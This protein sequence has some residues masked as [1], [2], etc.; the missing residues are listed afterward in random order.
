MFHC[1]GQLLIGWLFFCS[2]GWLPGL[3]AAEPAPDTSK[4]P[5]Q[6]SFNALGMESSGRW[7]GAPI[8]AL[9]TR[10]GYLWLGTAGGLAKFDGARFTFFLPPNAPAFLKQLI[11]CLYEDQEG[12]LW[13]GAD[14]GLFRYHKGNFEQIGLVDA[15]IS[16]VAQDQAGRMWIGTFGKGLYSWQNGQFQSYNSNPVMPGLVVRCL[17]VDSSDRIWVGFRKA[18][19][20]ICGEKGVFRHYDAGGKLH[21]EVQAVCEQ[22]RGTLWFGM[23]GDGIFRLKDNSVY[24]CTPEN[25]LAGT[26]IFDL[27]PS[28]D[29][30]VWVAEGL[31]QK[32]VDPD[33]CILNTIIGVPSE[34]IHAICEDRERNVW[35]CGFPDGLIRGCETPYRSISVTD[36]L[37]GNGVKTVKADGQGNLWMA[38]QHEGVVKMSPDGQVTTYTKNDGLPGDDPTLAYPA[39]DG[40]VWIGIGRHLCVYRDGA[41]KSYPDVPALCGAYEDHLGAMWLGTEDEGVFRYKDGAFG[42]V[43][44]APGQPI[45]HAT[46]FFETS[47]GTMYI[48]TWRSGI[49]KIKDGQ[50][51]IYDHNN[52]L[53]TDDV[54]AV[55]VD[56]E[57]HIWAGLRAEGLAVWQ[58]GRW[59]H[60]PALSQ[61]VAYQVT[62]IAEDD[63]HQLWLGTRHGV[64]W[65][66][67]DALL[68]AARGERSLPKLQI[69][70]MVDG[71]H[72]GSVWSGAQPV[73][74][75]RPDHSLLFATHFGVLVIDPDH[76]LPN[77]VPPPVHIEK[78]TLDGRTVDPADTI[79]IPAGVKEVVI[80]YTAL[81][82]SQPNL[83]SFK[84]MLEGCDRD[85][86]DVGT[87][88]VAFYGQ[89]PAR[90]YVFRVKACNSDGVWNDQGAQ[91]SLIQQ[92]HFYERWWFYGVFF[93][94]AAG[95]VL[96]FSRW[97]NH[98]LKLKLERLEQKQA[99]EREKEK[100]R[101]RIARNLH[102]GLGANLTEIGLFAETAKHPASSPQTTKD[103]AFLSERVRTM[104][105]ALDAVVWVVNPANDSLDRLS[106][107]ICEIFEAL[108]RISSIRGRQDVSGDIPPY[109]VT[110]EERSNFF[111]TAKEAINNMVKHSG[112]TEGRLRIKI[113]ADKFCLTLEDNGVG[114]DPSLPENARRNG[115]ANMRA[116]IA[117]LKG[118]FILNSTPGKGTSI[119]ISVSLARLNKDSAFGTR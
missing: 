45:P 32:I 70:D 49:F 113:E 33:R 88:R 37:P 22:P 60:T 80:E 5:K 118:T 14:R 69:V 48:G 87:R 12:N 91:I 66:P 11:H 99:M 103:M 110:P 41:F 4:R 85:W 74:W 52:G 84:Y 16:A 25:G 71:F 35:L 21:G 55:Y 81:S 46:S 82:F 10:D 106:A 15:S 31:L 26:Q 86:V 20:V 58:D 102:D 61:V 7:Q 95:A 2:S 43:E 115:L 68:A 65:A 56:K 62:A 104:A 23:R 77:A 40:T 108:L 8:A 90:K 38:V 107:Y 13:I 3:N 64:M 101:L 89:L 75:Q 72:V 94:G 100:E 39:S 50:M 119:L 54:R 1:L 79:Y 27:K 114:F 73:V 44:S 93:L 17:F 30:G 42:K 109:P 57:G 67:K 6:Y 111:L 96:G 98:Q 83:V 36:G 112:A 51:T 92:P 24:Q 53:P 28:L 63:R 59:T 18:S 34:T 97:S 9:Q 19:G 29:G 105:E 117:E 47:D 76:L 116:R 78:V